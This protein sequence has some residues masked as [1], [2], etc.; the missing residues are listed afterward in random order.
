MS[1]RRSK[2]DNVISYDWMRKITESSDAK[3]HFVGIGGVSMCS[4]ARLALKSGA[5][6]T[7]S[8]REM[9]GRTKRLATLGAIIYTEHKAENARGA[10]LVVYS[11]AIAMDN[12]ELA[13]A[14]DNGIPTV[15]R[16]EYLGALMQGYK[17]RIGVSGSHGKSTTVAMLDAIMT[18]AGSEPTVLSGAELSGGEPL[19]LG[20]V[21]ILNVLS[22]V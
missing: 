20:S 14:K 22:V 10:D 12:A 5:S 18:R 21:R 19:K 11:H 2:N 9:S 4:L 1:Q 13:F 8:D 17:H 6:V 16:A 3:I 15:S 7:G